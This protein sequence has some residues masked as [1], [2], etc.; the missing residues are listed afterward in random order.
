MGKWI[1]AAIS[2]V[3]FKLTL[4]L[5]A[6]KVCRKRTS[7]SGGEELICNNASLLFFIN[8]HWILNKTHR[9]TCENCSLHIIDESI[10]NVPKNNVT[11]LYL[12]S[13]KIQT[14]KEFAFSK[15][16]LLKVLN[17]CNN[18]IDELSPKSFTN[19]TKL[20][21][22]DLSYNKLTVLVNNMFEE[23]EAFTKLS[24]LKHLYLSS[25]ELEKLEG[26]TFRYLSNLFLLYLENNRIMEVDSFAFANLSK[27]NSLYLNNNNISFLIQ[28][29]F[30]PLSNLADLQLRNNNLTEI[31]TSSFNG[32][33]HLKSLYLGN[34]RLKTV[35]RYGFVGLDN[36]QNLE[37]IDNDFENFDLGFIHDMKNLNMLWLQQNHISNLTMNFKL[38]P[39]NSLKSLGINDNNFTTLNYKL[40]YHQ[41]PNI[42]DIFI[43]NNTWKCELLV[44]MFNFFQE[45]NVN[46]CVSTDCNVNKTRHY[47]EETC[48]SLQ[49]PD[50]DK[51]DSDTDFVTEMYSINTNL[52]PHSYKNYE[53][54]FGQVPVGTTAIKHFPIKNNH[55]DSLIYFVT[56]STKTNP[57]YYVFDIN[58]Y[59]GK[60]ESGAEF[61][62]KISYSPNLPGSKNYDY[63]KVVDSQQ[64]YYRLCVS[65]KCIGPSVSCSVRFM[66]FFEIPNNNTTKQVFQLTNNSEVPAIFQFDCNEEQDQGVFQINTIKGTIQPK[67]H[68]YI[69]EPI[70]LNLFGI[71]SKINYDTNYV[72]FRYYP[73][74][75]DETVG[76][77]GYLSDSVSSKLVLP[78]VSLSINNLDFGRIMP[79]SSCQTLTTSFTNHMENEVEIEWETVPLFRIYP[80]KLTIPSQKSALF[81]CSFNPDVIS[82]LSSAIINGHIS[83]ILTETVCKIMNIPI[84]INLRV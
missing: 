1:L 44:N 57:I 2:I 32:L 54:N 17:L 18:L 23:P 70:I 59:E 55:H 38:N 4:S 25:N 73:F 75:W 60:V 11:S 82:R 58:K 5:D 34:N 80:E 13:S 49:E 33:T 41:I 63:F 67:K 26:Y 79:Q 31:Q 56:R 47:V 14:I 65:G 24:N 76:F 10:F 62:L 53:I 66:S 81:E 69:T 52:D 48:A 22:L 39:L 43:Y 51:E 8:F 68:I 21:Q 30:K 29:N 77:K 83:W 84:P 15:F 72:S 35:K 16:K 40:L 46:L 3:I 19:L 20:I 9:L 6:T 61:V 27:L 36:L 71:F 12:I 78:P 74:P 64:N 50:D 37:L 45:K 42:Q 7:V 28:Y